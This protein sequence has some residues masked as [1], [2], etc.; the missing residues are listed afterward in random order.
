MTRPIKHHDLRVTPPEHGRGGRKTP[1][2][3][4]WRH[5]SRPWTKTFDPGKRIMRKLLL[6]TAAVAM[7]GFAD[8]SRADSVDLALADMETIT[9]GAYSIPRFN[10]HFDKVGRIDFRKLID[11]AARFDVYPDIKGNYADGEAAATAYG[12][13][14]F[15]ETLSFADTYEGYMSQSGSHAISAVAAPY[16]H[17]FHN[18]C[19]KVKRY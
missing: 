13:H 6:A 2:W 1:E 8:T 5:G 7:L 11:V 10:F 9:A 19:C 16:Q 18:R 17:G 3:V 12:K 4:R 15:T 14:T